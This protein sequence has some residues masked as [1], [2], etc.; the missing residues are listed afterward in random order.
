M[1]IERKAVCKLI[2]K[3][4]KLMV[5]LSPKVLIFGSNYSKWMQQFL[6]VLFHYDA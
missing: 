1:K 4:E 2:E 5:L 6:V 3:N